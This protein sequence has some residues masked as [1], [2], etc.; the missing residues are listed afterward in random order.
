MTEK[1]SMHM[2]VASQPSSAL[3]DIY[4]VADT[5]EAHYKTVLSSQ[6]WE[7][8][9]CIAKA[10]RN[11]MLFSNHILMLSAAFVSLT[12]IHLLIN[13]QRVLDTF[14]FTTHHLY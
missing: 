5:T 6:C 10:F 2:N 4:T 3:N 13:F 7:V 1:I 9:L 14:A 12:K 8:L 11:L